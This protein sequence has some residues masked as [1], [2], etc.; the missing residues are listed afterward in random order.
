MSKVPAA[1]YVAQRVT[2]LAPEVAQRVREACDY[3]CQQYETREALEATYT[4]G[5]SDADWVKA[6]VTNIAGED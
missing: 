2:R 5:I 6:A 1:V 4:D 3:I